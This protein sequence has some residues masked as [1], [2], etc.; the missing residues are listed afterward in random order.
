MVSVERR[1]KSRSTGLF[2]TLCAAMLVLA[3]VSQQPWAAGAR[4]LAKGAIVPLEAT[5]M[6]ASDRIGSITGMFGDIATLRA[7][8]QRLQD[9]NAEL[10]RQVAELNAAGLDNSALRQALAF[11]RTYGHAMVAA[12]VVGRGPDGFSVTIEID[13]GSADGVK[14]GMVAVSGAGLVGRVT[15]TGPHAA[16]IQTLAD[17]QSRVSGFLSKSGLEGTVGGGP[18]DLQMLIDP[19]VGASPSVG[20]WVMTSGVGGG[21]PRG[22]VIAQVAAVSHDDASTVDH[23]TLAWVNDPASLSVVLVITDF[24]PS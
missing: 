21:Y 24:M 19:R 12:Q 20:E 6:A 7:Q 2:G 9:Q 17:P 15:E 10:R 13:R 23:A 14:P 11:E 8:N 5:M 1:T 4:G 3:M 16:I 22:L 18:G